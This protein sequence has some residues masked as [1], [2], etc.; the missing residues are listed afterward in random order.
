MQRSWSDPLWKLYCVVMCCMLRAKAV[1]LAG[2]CKQY[3]TIV[4]CA[5]LCCV[6]CCEHL[7]QSRETKSNMG[8][9]WWPLMVYKVK[10]KTVSCEHSS[11][12]SRTKNIKKHVLSFGYSKNLQNS[13]F[14]SASFS[15]ACL[16]L[17]GQ[18]SCAVGR[19]WSGLIHP[20]DEKDFFHLVGHP[21]SNSLSPGVWKACDCGANLN[22]MIV[23]DATHVQVFVSCISIICLALSMHILL[24][25]FVVKF[26]RT[27]S[28]L[29][30]A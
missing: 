26:K 20:F 30:W 18:C 15:I 19:S 27:L 12:C 7:A 3:A 22:T 10:I 11:G 28:A 1:Y 13:K 4:Q 5:V 29:G 24:R 25:C 8:N 23:N 6:Q 9:Y 14:V 2:T 16:C 17:V 21:F